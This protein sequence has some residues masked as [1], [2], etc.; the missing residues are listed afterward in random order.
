MKLVVD[1]N[2]LFSALIKE[3]ITRELLLL[4]GLILYV[5]EFILE[6]FFKHIEELAE[7]MKI[8]KIEL[9]KKIDKLLFLSGIKVVDRKEFENFF[10]YAEK[11]SPDPNDSEY[12]ALALRLN[13]PIWSN[14]KRLKEQKII[15]IYSTMQLLG[16]INKNA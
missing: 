11:I 5:P 8:N 4:K 2:V 14:D 3:G 16:L 13:C 7:K 12:F 6:E 10:N 1:A 15:K 9:S